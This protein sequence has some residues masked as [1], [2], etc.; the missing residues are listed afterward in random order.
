MFERMF[1]V[2]KDLLFTLVPPIFCS[3]IWKMPN[4]IYKAFVAL[5]RLT[6]GKEQVM[7]YQPANEGQNWLY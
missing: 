3:D 6:I 4:K 7:H 2:T 5:R 1:K